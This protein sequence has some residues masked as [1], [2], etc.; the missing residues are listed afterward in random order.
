MQNAKFLIKP[1][2]AKKIKSFVQRYINTPKYKKASIKDLETVNKLLIKYIVSLGLMTQELKD[3]WQQLQIDNPESLH[4]LTLAAEYNDGYIG[5]HLVRMSLYGALLAEKMGLDKQTVQNMKFAVPMHDIGKIGI[6]DEIL[7]KPGKLTAEEF[8]IIKDHTVMG[9]HIL[10]S[11]DSEVMTLAREIAFSHHEK[12]DGSGYPLGISGEKIPIAGQIVGLLD[13]F[14]A[15]TSERPYK[16]VYPDDVAWDFVNI[17]SGDHFAPDV[18]KV[19]LKY[20]D[21]FIQI[22]NENK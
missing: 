14:E 5:S 10:A 7:L 3:Y 18:V 17:E 19:F 13:V 21:E 22:K 15:I 16:P 20:F 2:V 12:W 4:I 8:D 6:P 11:S 9:A 1:D